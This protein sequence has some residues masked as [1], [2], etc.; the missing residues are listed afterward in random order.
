MLT[1]ILTYDRCS[2]PFE[3]FYP[4]ARYPSLSLVRLYSHYDVYTVLALAGTQ[5]PGYGSTTKRLL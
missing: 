1:Y 4:S 2:L 3:L 5:N